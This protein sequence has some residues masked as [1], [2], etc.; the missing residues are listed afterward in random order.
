M[1][2]ESQLSSCG[3]YR[4]NSKLRT[5][6]TYNESNLNFNKLRLR[7]LRILFNHKINEI[8]ALKYTVQSWLAT[9][10]WILKS[11][12]LFVIIFNINI[13]IIPQTKDR[14]DIT[15]HDIALT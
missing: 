8:E 11:H 14:A 1:W 7:E 9:Y 10:R 15:M 5:S 4:V 3:L 6:R 13:V 2:F 12:K